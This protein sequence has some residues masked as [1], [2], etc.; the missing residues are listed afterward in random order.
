MYFYWFVGF[1]LL[2]YI[3]LSIGIRYIYEKKRSEALRLIAKSLDLSFEKKSSVDIERCFGHF[4]MFSQGCWK[5]II[6]RIY[7]NINGIDVIIFE[8]KYTVSDRS[9]WWTTY[10][11]TVVSFCSNKMCLPAFEL[12]PK[13][14]FHK[15]G[16]L[17]GYQDI[18]F[19]KHSYFSKYYSLKGSDETAIRTIFS[20]DKLSFF[21]QHKKI[22]VEG[23]GD[24]L[25][26]YRQKKRV[27]PDNIKSF[28]QEMQ[29]IQRLFYSG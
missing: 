8:Y 21:E 10:R 11:Q 13:K 29:K 17:L 24:T 20:P 12:R 14:F 18:D 5:K 26:C 25:L 23:Q 15:I 16:G 19:D 2:T 28:L 3:I 1:L 7:G 9:C 22:C 6:N 27:K 4:H